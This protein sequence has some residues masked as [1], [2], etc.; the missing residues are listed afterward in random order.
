MSGL[1]VSSR[2]LIELPG[3]HHLEQVSEKNDKPKDLSRKNWADVVI[4]FIGEKWDTFFKTIYMTCDWAKTLNLVPENNQEFVGNIRRT[5]NIIKLGHGPVEFF[6]NGY[7]FI[8]AAFNTY[9][10]PSVKNLCDTAI[11][12]NNCYSPLFDSAELA[13][14]TGLVAIP[15]ET[16]RTMEGFNGAALIIGMGNQTKEC[17]AKIANCKLAD[18]ETAKVKEEAMWTIS[19]AL[20][21]MAK[22]VSYIALGIFVVL[23]V[24]FNIVAPG[25]VFL[26]L[27][28]SALAFTI[29][30]YFHKNLGMPIEEKKLAL[31]CGLF[32]YS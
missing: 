28:T 8:N 7:K 3:I 18:A 29:F 30:G 4:G 22:A 14:K 16:F 20:L 27:S 26:A 5:A 23:S 10:K 2:N 17:I 25:I 11:A 6:E 12:L 13:M 21:D 19:Q 15:T 24:F 31:H 32:G 9:N 1:T